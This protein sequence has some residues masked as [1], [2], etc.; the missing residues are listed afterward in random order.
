MGLTMNFR[1]YVHSELGQ[2]CLLTVYSLQVVQVISQQVL[3]SC[4]VL[5]LSL[6]RCISISA[7]FLALTGILQSSKEISVSFSNL[8]VEAFSL[9]PKAK[10][11]KK[12][13]AFQAII[14]FN[15]NTKFF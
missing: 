7:G 3:G 2:T 15:A 9:P 4:S 6:T 10:H 8:C 14:S 5:S 12:C 13:I 11:D 1:T